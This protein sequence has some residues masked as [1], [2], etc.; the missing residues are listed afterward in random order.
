MGSEPNG[1]VTMVPCRGCTKDIVVPKG[2]VVAALRDRRPYIMFCS[3]R[4]QRRSIA[5]EGAA[6][7]EKQLAR[8][9]DSDPSV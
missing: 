8:H 4:C 5:K 7:Q 2:P 9:S 1:D 3:A 6:E